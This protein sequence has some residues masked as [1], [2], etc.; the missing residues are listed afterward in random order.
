ML[1]LQ[2]ISAGYGRTTVIHDFIRYNKSDIRIHL[3]IS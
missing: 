1:Q 3:Y 2:S